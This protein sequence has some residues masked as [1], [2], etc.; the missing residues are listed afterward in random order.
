M[1]PDEKCVR[2]TS[3]GKQSGEQSV[4]LAYGPSAAKGRAAAPT[5]VSEEE[6]GGRPRT[7]ERIVH[8]THRRG[9]T[10]LSQ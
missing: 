10:S 1:S 9:A 6:V 3:S 7:G 8:I 5:E 4:G 2:K